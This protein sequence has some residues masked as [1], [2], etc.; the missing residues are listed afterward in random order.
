MFGDKELKN[1]EGFAEF[2][3][4]EYFEGF[5]SLLMLKDKVCVLNLFGTKLKT[6]DFANVKTGDF[7][8]FEEKE[9]S[10]F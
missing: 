7:E 6:C 9:K 4:L 3:K 1:D 5:F 8:S 10:S 2:A